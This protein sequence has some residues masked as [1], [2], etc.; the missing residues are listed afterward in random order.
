MYGRLGRDAWP[1]GGRWEELAQSYHRLRKLT[2]QYGLIVEKRI[3]SLTPSLDPEYR[4]VLL[5]WN[6]DT[7]SR[8]ATEQSVLGSY[9][10]IE[11]AIGALTMLVGIEK[12]KVY[13]LAMFG[14]ND[15]R[16]DI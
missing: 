7:S 9:L 5:K 10:D 1:V 2:L 4:F 6:H 16:A 8:F 3:I 13:N 11:E 15:P 14:F 12:E